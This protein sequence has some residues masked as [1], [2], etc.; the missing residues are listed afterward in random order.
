MTIPDNFSAILTDLQALP[1]WP[2]THRYDHGAYAWVETDQVPLEDACSWMFDETFF[3]F[4]PWLTSLAM[5]LFSQ[6]DR[7]VI[8]MGS[9]NEVRYWDKKELAGY[10]SKYNPLRIDHDNTPQSIALAIIQAAHAVLV[11]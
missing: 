6:M 8:E 9:C 4:T 5:H 7:W 11:E 1:C 3:L 2:E 10:G